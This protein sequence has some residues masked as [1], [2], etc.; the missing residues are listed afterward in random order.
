MCRC[1]NTEIIKNGIYIVCKNCGEVLRDDKYVMQPEVDYDLRV[2]CHTEIVDK[3]SEIRTQLS[4]YDYRKLSGGNKELFSRLLK[5][6]YQYWTTN[7]TRDYKTNKVRVLIRSYLLNEQLIFNRNIS[8]QIDYI[9][10]KTNKISLRGVSIIYYAMA[11]LIYVL[12]MFKIP[13]SINFM[14]LLFESKYKN[15]NKKCRKMDIYKLILRF[16]KECKLKDFRYF[17]HTTLFEYVEW[18]MLK[19]CNKY[20]INDYKIVNEIINKCR[21][22]SYIMDNNYSSKLC[23]AAGIIYYIIS[24]LDIKYMSQENVANELGVSTISLRYS[25][26]DLVNLLNI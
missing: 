15:K 18:F 9:I 11:V 25:R 6:K 20:K 1:G 12:R 4:K 19:L 2:R 10:L 24:N 16:S 13:Y 8:K 3:F 7:G 14:C 5:Y 23:S 22:Y 26:N 21:Y 17:E